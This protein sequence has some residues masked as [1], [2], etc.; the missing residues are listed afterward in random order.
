MIGGRSSSQIIQDNE[1]LGKLGEFYVFSSH[2][3]EV[4][5]LGS[6]FKILAES[7]KCRVQAFQFK[8]KPIWGIQ[9]HP[10]MNIPAGQQY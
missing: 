7:E 5:N 4:Y 3:D 1:L 10:E 6:E 8:D 2:F 9:A